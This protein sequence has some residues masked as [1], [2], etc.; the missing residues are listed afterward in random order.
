MIPQ[1]SHFQEMNIKL[2]HSMLFFQQNI[3]GEAE[4]GELLRLQ[5]SKCYK[6]IP[7][8]FFENELSS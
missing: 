6:K 1:N 2:T 7:P 3:S 4:E 5:T 8:Y